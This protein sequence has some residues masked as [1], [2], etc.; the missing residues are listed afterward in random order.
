MNCRRQDH[1]P[2]R[3]GGAWG[4]YRCV[5]NGGGGYGPGTRETTAPRYASTLRN[6]A[7]GS[8]L[9]PYPI[10]TPVSAATAIR[11]SQ[12]GR[13]LAATGLQVLDALDRDILNV[14]SARQCGSC[15]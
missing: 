3:G 14:L 12:A 1:E 2:R 9:E 11:S 6:I 10:R 8:A 13:R 4:A 7:N 5:T 15:S